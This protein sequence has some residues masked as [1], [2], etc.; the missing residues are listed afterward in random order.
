MISSEKLSEA[1][2]KK[3]MKIDET[4]QRLSDISGLS[5]TQISRIENNDTNYSH[6]NAYNLWKTLKELE[7]D[8][9]TAEDVMNDSIRW[10]SPEDTVLEVRK[11]MKNN[12]YSQMPV[13]KDGRHI[14]R[15]NTEILMELD[16]P[17][18]KIMPYIGPSYSELGPK[19]PLE[20][21]RHIVKDDS[22]ALIKQNDEYKGLITVADII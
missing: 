7:E 17:D 22:A 15:I 20:S 9:K 8:Y 2:R 3:R 18:E 19:T 1:L 12:D 4:Q 14:G 21:I 6:K 10:A 13:K 16:H 11:V 5:I